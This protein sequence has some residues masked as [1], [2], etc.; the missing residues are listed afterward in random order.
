MNK[1]W[2]SKC[3]VRTQKEVFK[4]VPINSLDFALGIA[5]KGFLRGSENPFFVTLS[6][7]FLKK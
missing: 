4:K 2:P 6:R 1:R 7:E 3:M 5:P